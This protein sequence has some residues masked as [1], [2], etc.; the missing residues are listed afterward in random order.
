MDY[1]DLVRRGKIK[2]IFKAR[3]KI[4]V[5]NLVSHITQRA[6]GK[7][8]LFLEDS[9][10]LFFLARLKEISKRRSV[11]IYAFCLMSNHVHLL[12]SP[13]NDE[14]SWA[15]KDLFSPYAVMFNRKYERKGHLFA[16]PYHQAVCLDDT[17]LLAASLYVH[18]NPVR[19]GLIS[20]PRDYRWSSVRLYYDPEVPPA[21]VNPDFVLG[22]LSEDKRKQKE[23]YVDLL[24]KSAA[25]EPGDPLEN[26]DAIGAFRKKLARRFP[27]IFSGFVRKNVQQ[28]SGLEMLDDEAIERAIKSMRNKTTRTTPEDKRARK[29]LIEQ[30]IARGFKRE[31]IAAKLGVSRK[32]IYNTMKSVD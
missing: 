8:P 15:M 24:L 12:L 29:F 7:E 21:F 9:D 23:I 1:D 4:T 18:M 27:G 3:Q 2:R 32:T 10:Y 6:A 11:E 14:L 13:R 25:L 30:L 28:R 17:Y 31:E 26:P 16:G 22:L 20:D 19:A 5:P